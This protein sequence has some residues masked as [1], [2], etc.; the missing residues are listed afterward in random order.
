MIYE[1]KEQDAY[2]FAR[3]MRAKV[4]PFGDELR[5][6]QFCPYCNGGKH[7]D[8]NTFSINLKSGQ[9]KCLR[10]SCS[11]QGNMI[12][13]ARDFDFSLGIEVDEY[14]QPKKRYRK[15]KTPDKPIEPKPKAIEYLLKRGISESTAQKY[16]ITIHNKRDNVLVFPFFDERGLLQY[17][18]YRDTEYTAGKTYT[19][20]DGK[21]H[22]SP[23]EWMEKDCKPILFGMKQCNDKFDRL[24]ITEGQL[25]SLSVAEAGFENAVSVPGGM[26]NFRWV[27]YCWNWMCQFEEIVVFGDLEN[28]HM[29]LLDDIKRRFP[30]KIRYVQDKD[31]Q[32]CKDANELLMKHGKDAVKTAVDNAILI[33]VE[34]IIELSDVE[35]V[36]IYKLEKLSSSINEVDRLLYGGLPFGGVVLVSGKPGE[37]KSTLASQILAGAIDS[38]YKVLAYSGELPNYQFKS[39][40]DFQ[41]A[42]PAHVIDTQN[43]FGDA[44]RVIS[45]SNRQLITEWYRGKAFMYDN[46]IVESDEKEDLIKTIKNAIMQYDTRVILIDN[47]MT[48]IDLDYEKGT[49]KYERQSA[50]MKKL[51]RM[52]L[53]F[54]VLILVVAHKRKNNFSDNENDEVSGSGDITGLAT[55]TMSYGKDKDAQPDE[56][57]LRI[58]KNRLFGKV[59]TTGYNLSYDEKSKRIYTNRQELERQFGWNKS[60]DGFLNVEQ[61]EIPFD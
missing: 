9:F 30:N 1:F 51:A 49:D 59:N 4:K 20:S 6:S 34:R 33:P 41:I 38:G 31:Y 61:G 32:G 57:T 35:D 23:K 10:S 18:K 48:A 11:V 42:G 5:F 53:Q 44:Y 21:S 37:G 39:W 24:I 52:A 55:I 60:D 56:R 46:R 25:D 2:D 27:P 58:S 15:L 29:T 54:D 26:N 17:I 28:G 50:F 19:D 40:I 16:E 43:K 13:L 3:H 14:Y 22:N 36:D 7:H 47:L 45:K 8:M 12:T